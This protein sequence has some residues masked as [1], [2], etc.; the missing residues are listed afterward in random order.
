[1]Y[2]KSDYE[3]APPDFGTFKFYIDRAPEDPYDIF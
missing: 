1:M 2:T 3:G